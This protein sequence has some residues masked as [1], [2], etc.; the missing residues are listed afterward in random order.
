M[1]ISDI[2]S[3]DALRHM[4]LVANYKAIAPPYVTT[5]RDLVNKKFVGA[6]EVIYLHTMGTFQRLEDP[7]RYDVAE[8]GIIQLSNS[9]RNVFYADALQPAEGED[10]RFLPTAQRNLQ[11]PLNGVNRNILSNVVYSMIEIL[12]T[13]NRLPAPPAPLRAATVFGNLRESIEIEFTNLF[14]QNAQRSQAISEWIAATAAVAQA[15]FPQ[16]LDNIDIDRAVRNFANYGNVPSEVLRSEE[17][18]QSI[19][20]QRAM[21][22]E[23]ERSVD[24]NS[25][26]ADAISKVGGQQ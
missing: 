11:P 16:A 10:R 24:M 12:R 13:G 4:S 8:S 26:I 1:A 5:N 14:S 18:V 2:K 17:D 7:I 23:E 20:E 25:K 3:L 19:R 6:N 9:I 15:G 22:A 21:L